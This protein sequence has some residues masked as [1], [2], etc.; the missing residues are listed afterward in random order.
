MTFE[1]IIGLAE[2]GNTDA[3]VA[4][5]QEFVWNEHI[6]IEDCDA[7]RDK[8]VEY[9]N[10]AIMAGNVDAMNQL[11]AMYAEGRIVEK[12][13][14]QAFR[15][16][17]LAAENGHALATSNLGFCYLYGN[18][19]DVDYEEAFKAFSKAALLDIGDAIVQLGDMYMYGW[20]VEK[21]P[22]TAYKYYV[23][24]RQLAVRDLSDW[25][26]QQVYSDSVYR[27]GNCFF[28][29]TGVEQDIMFAIKC[30]GDALYY[31]DL[32]E[33]RG[34]SYSS[35]GYQRTLY[36]LTEAIGRISH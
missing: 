15:F 3:M 23:K 33:K 6:N 9:L 28:E 11:A 19:T 4:A 10:A 21:D 7:V 25:G 30:Y 31:F 22:G 32:R 27:I 24:A 18:G 8:T 12:D 16:Y 35:K 13:P 20:F 36:R 1:E 26:M 5:I 29:G 17:K 34:D 14:A 2:A